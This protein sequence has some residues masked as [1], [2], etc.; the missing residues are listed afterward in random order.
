MTLY[1]PSWDV[2][3]AGNHSVIDDYVRIATTPGHCTSGLTVQTH[4]ECALMFL[5]MSLDSCKLGDKGQ[6]V[7]LNLSS[8]AATVKGMALTCWHGQLD[9]YSLKLLLYSVNGNR[10]LA[11][12]ILVDF[13]QNAHRGIAPSQ[14]RAVV[15]IS[16]GPGHVS[17]PRKIWNDV[18]LS[19]I[20]HL[21]ISHP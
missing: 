16:Q 21:S 8:F 14:Q 2:A 7:L 1:I 12:A 11:S 17:K 9:A 5:T 3:L 15:W 19:D 6:S 13:A 10:D 18:V 20:H 4:F